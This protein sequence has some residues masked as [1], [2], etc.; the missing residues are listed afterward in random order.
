MNYITVKQ[1]YND[2][3]KKLDLKIITGEEFLSKKKII[4]P[5]IN[6][7]GLALAGF[8]DYFPYERIQIFGKTEFTYL[9]KI[10]KEKTQKILNKLFS[11]NICCVLI[12]RNLKPPYN[13]ELIAEKNKIP[14]IMSSIFTTKLIS[15]V[16]LYLERKLAPKIT[17]HG[18][19]IDVYG[20]GVLLVGKSGIGKSEITLELIKRGHRLISDDIIEISKMGDDILEGRGLNIIQHHMEIRGLGIIDVKN[21]FGVGAVRESQKVELLIHLEE[22]EK[23]KNYERLGMEEQ[24]EEILGVKVPKI[25]LP[26]KPG[27]NLSVIIEVAAMTQRLKSHGYNPAKELNK[28]ILK[29]MKKEQNDAMVE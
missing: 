20:I 7:P 8:F 1:F 4:I 5:E 3:K 29:W 6:R 28:T 15:S 22:W 12:S 14:V 2:N 21:L 24:Y 19:F 10:G 9:K 26:V 23:R 17:L 13:F 11:Y 25:I 27:R 16:M 18:T